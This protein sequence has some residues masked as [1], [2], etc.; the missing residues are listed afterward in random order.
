[1]TKKDTLATCAERLYVVEGMTINE[2]A[3]VLKVHEK[4]I[5]NWKE[6]FAWIDKREK[7]DTTK[8]MFHEDLYNFA[9]KLMASIEYDMDEQNKIDPGRMYA[10]TKMLPLINK[11]K[12][13]EDGVIQKP[14]DKEEQGLTP[15][16]IRKIESEILGIKSDEE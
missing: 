8:K 6:E 5:R 15:E 9:R 3:E 11:I 12:E 7:Y 10:F 14:S 13:Y 4:S 1:L 2:I 16:M